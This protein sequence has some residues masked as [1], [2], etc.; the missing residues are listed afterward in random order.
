MDSQWNSDV[1]HD[2]RRIR[3]M[4]K[5][6]LAEQSAPSSR[7]QQ[8]KIYREPYGPSRQFVPYNMSH[9]NEG[10]EAMNDPG[11]EGYAAGNDQ[12]IGDYEAGNADYESGTQPDSHSL[13]CVYLLMRNRYLHP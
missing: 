7:L 1:F 11:Y 5:P 12:G 13:P 6:P 9:P 3:L 8:Q 10:I 2:P 4:A